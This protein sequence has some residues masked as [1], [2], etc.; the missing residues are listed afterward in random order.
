IQDL[1][2]VDLNFPLADDGDLILPQAEP[3][4]PIGPQGTGLL[5]SS[6]AP[7]DEP[8]SEESAIAPQRKRREPKTLPYDRTQ[9]LRNTILA[10]WSTDYLT[11]MEEA[12]KLK[13]PRKSA[14]ITKQNAAFWVFGAGI[15][16]VSISRG[17]SNMKGPLAD[18]FSGDALMAALTG[19]SAPST[20]RKRNRSG[21]DDEASD[22]EERRVKMRQDDG[23]VGRAQG[24]ILD[25]DDALVLL[26]SEAIELPRHAPPAL[27]DTSQFPWNRSASLRDSRSRQ[28]SL[29]LGF[30][31]SIGGGGFTTTIAGRPSSLPL[32]AG[33]LDRRASRRMTSAS[34]LTGRGPAQE[35][36][37]DLD[38]PGFDDNDF[39]GG[40]S[41]SIAGDNDFQLYG[42]AAGVDTQTAAQSQWVRAT[43]DAESNN[44]LEFIKA[45]VSRR[46]AEEEMEA[47]GS[48]FFEELL[49]PGRNSKIV[50]AQGL[51]HALTLA[52]K[53][54]IGVVQGRHYGG[55]EMRVVEGGA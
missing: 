14:L 31:S 23:E 8:S 47:R 21:D 19:F 1:M 26:G 13:L 48:V 46:A 5:R 9:E 18:M 11:N 7:R 51:L 28:G 49:P 33:S 43:L 15:G 52:T 50:A 53:G 41:I 25:D 3:F 36:H 20:G 12:R 38:I 42:P 45:E 44:F 34:P 54:L 35:H 16:G 29:A 39:L 4:P 32:P 2:D 27:D 6:A 55:I 10:Q 40:P 30:D 37:S 24:L 17:G 22:S